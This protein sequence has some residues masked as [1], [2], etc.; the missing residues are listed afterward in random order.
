MVTNPGGEDNKRRAFSVECRIDTFL[1]HFRRWGGLV[2]AAGLVLAGRAIVVLRPTFHGPT[3]AATW[4]RVLFCVCG[5]LVVVW[6]AARMEVSGP[7]FLAWTV[8]MI[9]AVWYAHLTDYGMRSYDWWGHD[10]YVNYL[11]DNHRFPSPGQ[12]WT[13]YHPPLYFMVAAVFVRVFRAMPR[14]L[15]FEN[16]QYLSTAFYG[17]YL[18]AFLRMLHENL[19]WRLQRALAFLLVVS[20]P[21]ALM[22]SARIGNDQMI[23]TLWAFSLLYTVRWE[24]TLA[25]S[26]LVAATVFLAV[27]CATKIN[28]VVPTAATGAA[29]LTNWIRKPA[30]RR[31]IVVAAAMA[32]PVFLVGFSFYLWWS[33]SYLKVAGVAANA[34]MLGNPLRV[35]PNWHRAFKIEP[36]TFLYGFADSM[37]EAGGRRFF[38]NY[39]LKTSLT[40]EWHFHQRGTHTTIF[41][42]SAALLLFLIVFAVLAVVERRTWRKIPSAF[43]WTLIFSPMVSMAHWYHTGYSSSGDARY[44]F[45]V[46]LAASIIFVRLLK[47][48]DWVG[49]QKLARAGTAVLLAVAAA[50]LTFQGIVV[51]RDMFG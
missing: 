41:W 45:P 44:V 29:I 14:Q 12:C 51:W 9:S 2:A 10:A 39:F 8:V 15:P 23:C 17:L 50:G 16:L 25:P 18:I 35:W 33:R 27:G 34:A 49:T 22:H 38:W 28:V 26:D 1:F 40:G 48:A 20:V 30:F 7:G 36:Y 21:A 19:E 37:D 42:L 47:D 43:T 31:D 32:L 11:V 6:V 24:R 4:L 3:P 13:C 46:W 5:A